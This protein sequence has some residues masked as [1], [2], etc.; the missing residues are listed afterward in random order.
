MTFAAEQNH[1]AATEEYQRAAQLEP[2]LESVYYRLGLSQ[3]QLKNYDEAISAFH[4][5]REAQGDNYDTETALAQAYSAKGMQVEA[6]AASQKAE[7]LKP[8]Q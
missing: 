6:K 2:D 3:M 7:E 8:K 1:T 5:Q 4:Q